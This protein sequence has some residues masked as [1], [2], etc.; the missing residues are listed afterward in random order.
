MSQNFDVIETT[1]I[2]LEPNF[3][4][5]T[6]PNGKKITIGKADLDFFEKLILLPAQTKI[7]MME[8]T[9]LEMEKYISNL[10]NSKR[11]Q[12][13]NVLSQKWFWRETGE[14]VYINNG[15]IPDVNLNQDEMLMKCKS[16]RPFK[17]YEV[18]II[19]DFFLGEKSEV[20]LNPITKII[21]E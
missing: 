19:L 4:L 14:D 3:R 12:L 9:V 21:Y 17:L 2:S 18:E 20:Y 10:R 15:I 7:E 8:L 1:S 16:K 11:K 13:I 5:Y 6:L